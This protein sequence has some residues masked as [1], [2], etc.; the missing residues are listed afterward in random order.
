MSPSKRRVLPVVAAAVM[1]AGQQILIARRGE[2]ETYAGQW[3]FPGGKIETGETPVNALVRE[4]KEELGLDVDPASM[5][6]LG[7]ITHAYTPYDVQLEVFIVQWS[8]QVIVL[9]DHSEMAWVSV[10]DLQSHNL[11]PADQPF[12][13]KIRAHLSRQ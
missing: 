3:E 13:E 7:K 10:S 9:A 1:N 4:L 2:H 5:V 11:A 6:S 12:I 8:G